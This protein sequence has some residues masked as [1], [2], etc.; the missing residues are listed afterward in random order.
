MITPLV[1]PPQ[2]YLKECFRYER[3]TGKL[4]WKK[5]PLKHFVSA[6]EHKRWNTRYAGAETFKA[7]VE[8]GYT[9][10]RL[11]GRSYLTHRVVWKLVR[12][13]EP[14][15]VVGHKDGVPA[16]NRN[17]NLREATTAQNCSNGKRKGY[18]FDRHKGYWL[19]HVSI[20]GKKKIIAH[21]KSEAEAAAARRVAATQTYGEFART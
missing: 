16:N 1:L 8:W 4:F 17:E 10:G 7:V 11:D 21:C 15:D 20:G 12:G 6:R 9:R 5:R 3:S 2:K 13:T 14:P 18:Y 19:A